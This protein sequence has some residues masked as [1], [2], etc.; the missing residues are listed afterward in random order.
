MDNR[1]DEN[2][3]SGGTHI[4]K[5]LFDRYERDTISDAQA[6]RVFAPIVKMV[7]E[8]RFGHTPRVQPRRFWR[9]L[10]VIGAVAVALAI[11]IAG[12]LW[13]GTG[14]QPQNAEGLVGVSGTGIPLAG[15][16]LLA[17]LGAD[18]L[19]VKLAPA[20]PY[21]DQVFAIAQMGEGGVYAFAMVPDGHYR[22][23]SFLPND[24]V[25]QGVEVGNLVV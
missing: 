17:F 2:P 16:N 4:L 9:W 19:A 8:G 15:P 21:D 7:K 22:V 1:T 24:G 12:C 18:I 13:Q 3:P 6:R 25:G 20:A 11:A 10:K 5:Q 23:L 14:R